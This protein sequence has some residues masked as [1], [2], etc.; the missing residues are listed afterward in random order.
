MPTTPRKP[1]A[2]NDL[3]TLEARFQAFQAN[4]DPKQFRSSYG[5]Y[6]ALRN[7]VT[8]AAQAHDTKHVQYVQQLDHAP[9]ST[10]THTEMP[11]LLTR[12]NDLHAQMQR[13]QEGDAAKTDEGT[14]DALMQL[15]TEANSV[16]AQLQHVLAQPLD[17]V[18]VR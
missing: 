4:A 14:L 11:A 17:V 18:H 15:W 3:S 13:L 9:P 12:Y 2:T 1:K 7:D 16:Y 8:H 5:T 6:V 10:A